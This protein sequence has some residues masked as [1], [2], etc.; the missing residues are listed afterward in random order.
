MSVPL[1]DIE[2]LDSTCKRSGPPIA[3]SLSEVLARPKSLEGQRIAVRG[4]YALFED[5]SALYLSKH[6]LEHRRRKRAIWL[7]GAHRPDLAGSEVV[8]TGVLTTMDLGQSDDWP[9]SLCDNWQI[10]RAPL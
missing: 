1:S 4:Y 10:E 2:H 7:D 9:A 3:V 6:D 8:A 5:E